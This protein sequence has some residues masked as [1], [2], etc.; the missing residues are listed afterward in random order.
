MEN[1]LYEFMRHTYPGFIEGEHIRKMCEKLMQVE[2]GE[3]KRLIVTMPPRHSKSDTVST[4]FP[5]WY[6]GRNPTKRIIT[7]SYSMDLAVDI[8][9]AVRNLIQSPDYQ[10]IWNHQMSVDT[11]KTWKIE[12]PNNHRP[13]YVATGVMGG[14][15]GRGSDCFI[16]DDPIKNMEEALSPTYRERLW[17]WYQSAARTRLQP[18]ASMI[19]IQTRWSH[20]DLTG[21]LLKMMNEES[22][23][24]W[25][26]LHFK[27]IQDDGSAL[28]P[29]MY[30]LHELEAIRSAVGSR[31]F[32]ALYQG[33]PSTE[34]GN[35]LKRE[36]WQFYESLKEGDTIQSWDTAYKTGQEND[37]SVCWTLRKCDTGIYAIDMLRGKWEYPEMKRIAVQ[38]YHQHKPSIVLIEDH[39]S[40]QTLIQ[41]LRRSTDIPIKPIRADRDKVSRVNAIANTIEG[42]RLYLPSE[43]SWTS[44]AIE[45]CA[46]FPSGEHDDIVDA[47]SQGIAYFTVDATMDVLSPA[48]TTEGLFRS[49]MKPPSLRRA[50]LW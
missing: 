39:A 47:L 25:D 1:D 30:D 9:N 27:A 38:H 6:L 18:G 21:R 31:T 15:T 14:Q 45:E 8:S 41:D 12:H 35:I 33:M 7:S 26:V 36:W 19:I 29:E 44:T 42:G 3:C 23:E 20:D 49:G 17:R 28:W 34:E 46:A 11:A 32:N 4:W 40:G 48:G 50:S 5:A 22:S 24:Q 13:T 10:R 43:Q 16:I 37:Y 2:K